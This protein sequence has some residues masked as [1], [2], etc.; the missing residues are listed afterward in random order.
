MKQSTY[1][2]IVVL[3]STSFAADAAD[4]LSDTHR[5][6]TWRVHV[7]MSNAS[8]DTDVLLVARSLDYAQC[9]MVL[10][11][12]HLVVGCLEN[13]MAAVIQTPCKVRSG[14]NELVEVTYQV[15]EQPTKTGIFA[16]SNGSIDIGSEKGTP[17][18]IGELLGARTLRAHFTTFA[19]DHVDVAFPVGGLKNAL[20]PVRSACGW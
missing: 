5:D 12:A 16:A 19:G 10:R 13:E 11:T 17:R 15:D 2:A 3:F 9:G 7:S 1:V 6:E 18:F 14:R 4:T 20:G 8:D